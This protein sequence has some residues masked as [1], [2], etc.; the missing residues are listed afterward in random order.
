MRQCAAEERVSREGLP[1]GKTV[2][3]D[4]MRE[5]ERDVCE[6]VGKIETE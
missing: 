3:N 6:T 5:K 1:G 2:K 4:E